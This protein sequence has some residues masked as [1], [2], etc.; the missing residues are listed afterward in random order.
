MPDSC[1]ISQRTMTDDGKGGDTETWTPQSTVPCRIAPTK[2]G[3]S[4]LGMEAVGLIDTA[5][6]FDL[7]M[8]LGTPIEEQWQVIVT[9]AETSQATEYRVIGVDDRGSYATATRAV[10]RRAPERV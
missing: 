7:T 1:V 2:G 4:L 6:T 3:G 10:C 5:A 8:P 9:N